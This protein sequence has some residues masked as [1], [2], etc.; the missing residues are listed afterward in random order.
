MSR[1][2]EVNRA[3]L[4]AP[5]EIHELAN[6]FDERL[7]AGESPQIEGVLARRSGCS[8][9]ALLREL[10]AIEAEFRQ[11]RGETPS[12]REYRDRFPE[13]S[14]L[15]DEFFS[16]LETRILSAPDSRA[17]EDSTDVDGLSKPA[18]QIDP[19]E[20]LPRRFGPFEILEEIGRGGMG[21]VHRARELDSCGKIIRDVALKL[22]RA[23]RLADA[24][25]ECRDAY[26]ARF[27][28][29]ARAV[30]GLQHENIVTLYAVGE[31]DGRHYYSM[32][33]IEGESLE[34]R[35]KSGPLENREAARV[36]EAAAR[37]VQAA[38][39]HEK[40]ILHRDLKPDNIL[41]ETATGRA[42]VTDFGLAKLHDAESVTQTG[43]VFG[44][45]SYMSPEQATSSGDVTV[46]TDIYGLGATLYALLT[47]LPPFRAATP[48]ETLRQVLEEETI[49]PK[50]LQP[51]VDRDLETICLKCLEKEPAKRY[52]SAGELA[53]DLERFLNGEPIVARPVGR[54]ERRWRW[55]KRHPGVALLSSLLVLV[56][57]A[58][59]IG[60]TL[61][62]IRI[63]R[64]RGR[65]E[66]L[67]SS[68]AE[69]RRRAVTANRAAQR[70]AE[71]SRRIA[72]FLQKLVQA[73][74]PFNFQGFGFQ[75]APSTQHVVITRQ[76]L[77][78]AESR[79]TAGFADSP[80]IQARMRD[81][82]GTV[83]FSL[84]FK[85]KGE[86]LVRKALQQ[87]QKLLG[88]DHP[89]VAQSLFHLGWIH[90]TRKGYREAITLYDRSLAILR[91]RS[92][93]E[94][95]R[96]EIQYN[97]AWAWAELRD[98]P[99]AE[100][101]FRR[102]LD[103]RKTHLSRNHPLIATTRYGLVTCLFEQ[104]K[105]NQAMKLALSDKSLTDQ[106]L[107]LFTYA[108]AKKLRAEKKFDAAAEAYQ[109]LMAISRRMFGEHPITALIIGDYAVTLRDAGRLAEAEVQ[110]RTAVEMGKKV[111]PTH[112]KLIEV[113]TD[114]AT[115]V[116]NLGRW[117]QAE[118]LLREALAVA[119]KRYGHEHPTCQDLRGRISGLMTRQSRTPMPSKES[120]NQ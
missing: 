46:A 10:L 104:N 58:V 71:A 118:K 33:Y 52:A 8:R 27:Q 37:A 12:A 29:E 117:K 60:S 24:P 87:R 69:Q 99:K 13:D 41:I 86:N 80:R 38:H 21:V 32:Q 68:E 106:A 115:A 108:R 89:E 51:A 93:H 56:L 120:A 77:E 59:S 34:D 114:W 91:E 48:A 7:H 85:V 36:V 94:L 47:G 74:S 88:K 119:K 18:R 54:L 17:G 90:H 105:I 116:E 20:A 45:P 81:T 111:L 79:L 15:I 112:P 72:E 31:I 53:A 50:R 16:S 102:A 76:E 3:A 40:N 84:G 39:E 62:A 55:A 103:S 67:A 9:T 23:D 101:L 22:I 97:K 14:E 5:D 43:D 1:N 30:A 82:L 92:G 57:V 95:S 110:M 78:D 98:Y 26:V 70:E 2:T 65:A 42:L 113:L 64:A 61:A 35:L 100:S 75:S 25:H 73:R 63:D 19:E 4:Q 83:A 109:K 11:S 44:S 6:E 28:D 49:P 66:A 96:A 107:G